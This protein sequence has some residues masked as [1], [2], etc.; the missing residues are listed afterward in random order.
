MKF[1]FFII[2]TIIHFLTYTDTLRSFIYDVQQEKEGHENLGNFANN[3][4]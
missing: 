4:G 2:N 3:F 1:N